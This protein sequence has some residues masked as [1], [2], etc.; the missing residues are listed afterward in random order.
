MSIVQIDKV[1]QNQLR[2]S[3]KEQSWKLAHFGKVLNKKNFKIGIYTACFNM[4]LGPNKTTHLPFSEA[5]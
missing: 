2:M 1:S 4:A 5:K 3:Y